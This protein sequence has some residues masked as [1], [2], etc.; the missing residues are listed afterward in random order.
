MCVSVPGKVIEIDGN[1]ATIDFSGSKMTIDVS[2]VKPKVG[3][4]VLVH[5]GCALEILSEDKAEEII[6][7]FKELEEITGV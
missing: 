6:T 2:L 4:Y 3:Q 7:L 5:A 1:S